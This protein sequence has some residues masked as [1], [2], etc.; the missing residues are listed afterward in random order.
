MDTEHFYHGVA[1]CSHRK[2]CAE[3]SLN[4]LSI[5]VH[6]A[7]TMIWV[8]LEGSFPPAEVEDR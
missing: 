1:R 6:K 2:F 4:F 5:F 3:F 7:I 8:S